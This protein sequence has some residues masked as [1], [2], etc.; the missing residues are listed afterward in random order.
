MSQEVVTKILNVRFSGAD[1][2]VEYGAGLSDTGQ[3]VEYNSLNA[4]IGQLRPEGPGAQ[5]EL[6][7][8]QVMPGVYFANDGSDTTEYPITD[9]VLQVFPVAIG[10]SAIEY[11]SMELENS[12]GAPTPQ[13]GLNLNV[14][15]GY[16]PVYFKEVNAIQIVNL[17]AFIDGMVNTGGGPPLVDQALTFSLAMTYIAK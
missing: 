17:N 13:I 3:C 12:G 5:I 15:G 9:I 7:G 6:V 1:L 8:M 11:N 10:G 2:V 4:P 14:S 16:T